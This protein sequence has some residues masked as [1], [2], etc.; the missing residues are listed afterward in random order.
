MS[1]NLANPITF[2]GG[3]DNSLGQPGHPHTTFG[4]FEDGGWTFRE[5]RGELVYRKDTRKRDGHDWREM[6]LTVAIRMAPSDFTILQ[7]EEIGTDWVVLLTPGEGHRFVVGRP[8]GGSVKEEEMGLSNDNVRLWQ[9]RDRI[10]TMK[11]MELRVPNHAACRPFADQYKR[12]NQIIGPVLSLAGIPAAA[13][14]VP[15]AAPVAP[16]AAPVVPAPAPAPQNGSDPFAGVW[17]YARTK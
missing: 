3:I 2:V 5:S 13:S 10:E 12:G 11:F 4:Y 14:F 1:Q 16:V 15:A 9:Q 7:N 8:D 17:D 6:I